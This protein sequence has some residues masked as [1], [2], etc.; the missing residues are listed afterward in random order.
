MPDFGAGTVIARDEEAGLNLLIYKPYFHP[1]KQVCLPENNK[2]ARD[3][4]LKNA[5]KEYLTAPRMVLGETIPWTPE[6]VFSR[7]I[8]K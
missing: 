5:Y 6:N 4:L 2:I 1:K 7:A 3:Y 8:Q